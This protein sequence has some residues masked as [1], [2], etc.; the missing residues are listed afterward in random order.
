MLSPVIRAECGCSDQRGADSWRAVGALHRGSGVAV[1]SPDDFFSLCGVAGSR[2]SSAMHGGGGHSC[3]FV[4]AG[5]HF[6]SSAMG[7]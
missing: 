2:S 3:H 5:H 1:C 7:N 6:V 4:A